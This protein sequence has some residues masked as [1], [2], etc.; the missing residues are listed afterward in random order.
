MIVI[1][2]LMR[3]AGIDW[4]MPYAYHPD[5][6][7]LVAR[8]IHFL[9]GD[10]NP[11]LFLYPSL[12]MYLLALLNLPI[13]LF[14][15][16][17]GA[18]HSLREFTALYPQ[19][20]E[21]F[22]IPGRLL[23]VLFSVLAIYGLYRLARLM[24]DHKTGLL[25]ALF[26]TL[27]PAVVMHSYFV[28]TDIPTLPFLIFAF[29]YM[30][31]ITRSAEKKNY[32]LAALFVGLAA[33]IKYNAGLM[34]A[35]IPL[36][37]LLRNEWK[38]KTLY[39][40]WLL[41]ALPLAPLIF[42]CT[43]PYVL[44]D[45]KCF[46]HDF[47]LQLQNQAGGLGLASVGIGNCH[48]YYLTHVWRALGGGFFWILSLSSL[49]FAVVKI[50]NS[51]ERAKERILLMAWIA[52]YGSL[53]GF[54]NICLMRYFLPL[55]PFICLLT[56]DATI[57]WLSIL[58]SRG[59][60]I[61]QGL[62]KG[63]IIACLAYLALYS[64]TLA[65][66]IQKKDARTEAKQWIEKHIPEGATIG[67]MISP[68]GLRGRDDPP[69]EEGRYIIHQSN[70]L[71]DLLNKSPEY[72]MLSS[73]DYLDLLRIGARDTLWAPQYYSLEALMG[74]KTAY[75]LLKVFDQQPQWLGHRFLGK[76]PLHDMMYCFPTIELYQKK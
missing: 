7:L 27:L 22:Y 48:L 55:S 18:W 47:K 57:S 40:K 68:V 54:S 37:H 16:I 73:Y 50:F 20:L 72:I 30:A 3:L 1:G 34:I 74:G 76:Y 12:Q 21:I 2:L 49:C 26:L 70:D 52:L 35:L 13:F 64:F 17:S 14:G 9:S 25:A 66:Q 61:W 45:I 33:G 71:N 60:V 10:L 44:L 53:I 51:R 19:H 28:T 38:L 65:R 15:W 29:Y 69:L 39:N 43:S 36:A 62:V 8:G 46:I 23:T 4:G 41:L 63:A 42:L 58:R 59:R 75:Q 24:F 31:R 67:S 32:L 56:A 11:H 5:E 6:R